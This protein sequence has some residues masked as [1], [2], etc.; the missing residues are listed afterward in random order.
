M[1][2]IFTLICSVFLIIQISN[3]Q[4][5]KNLG[6]SASYSIG[7]NLG[8]QFS[9]QGL[10]DINPDILAQAIKDVVGNKPLKI[11]QS[12]LS[13]IIQTYVEKQKEKQYSKNIDLS[14]SF[15]A[16]N[17]K[18]KEVITL[19][20]GL[21]YEILV[22]GNG[23]I[24]KISDKVEVHY[25]GTLINGTVFDSSV[26]RGQTITFDVTG[27]IKGWTEALQLMPVGSKWKLYIPSELA[28]GATPRPGGPI[29]PYMALIFEVELISIVK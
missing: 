17:K 23:E 10:T 1:K 7:I 26:E 4:D 21:Q 24:P 13:K 8:M 12:Q 22:K 15:L 9:Q 11:D 19:P 5:L 16:E 3:A 14:K 29:E 20:S 18:R 6:D 27:V 25:H 28:Y 2:R